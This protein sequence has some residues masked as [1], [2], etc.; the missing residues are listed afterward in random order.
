MLS[1]KLF[2]ILKWIAM[3]VLPG[4][5]TFYFAVSSI[6][7]LPY[8][9]EIVGSL[10]AVNV[11]LSALLAVSNAQ[12]QAI[13]INSLTYAATG[14]D[15]MIEFPQTPF[16]ITA[17]SYNTL[18]WVTLAFLPASGALYFTLAI[19]WGFPF[20]EQVV[21]TIVALTAFMGLLLGVSKIRYNRE[22]Q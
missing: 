2:D 13:K 1:N 14:E 5:A 3:P 18:K 4:L 22:L 21:G 7:G 16:G 8:Q 6:W 10:V 19:L 20:G 15:A 12:W 11:W 17:S 9:V